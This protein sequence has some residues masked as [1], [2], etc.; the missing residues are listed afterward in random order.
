[1]RAFGV[2]SQPRGMLAALALG[3]LLAGCA[4]APKP[5]TERPSVARPAPPAPPPPRPPPPRAGPEAGP[6]PPG[7]PKQAVPGAR[8]RLRADHSRQRLQRARPGVVVREEIP[9]PAHRQRRDLRH[10]RDDGSAS[11]PAA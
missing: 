7:G 11:D 4:S 1:M 8:P 6:H 5:A 3:L 9:R 2:L 10:V